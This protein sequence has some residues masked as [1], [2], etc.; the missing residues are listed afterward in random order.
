MDG[1][2]Y[3]RL[4]DSKRTDP[5][6]YITMIHTIAS[7]AFPGPGGCTFPPSPFLIPEEYSPQ[8][9]VQW[10]DFHGTEP[11]TNSTSGTSGTRRTRGNNGMS[12]RDACLDGEVYDEL[13]KDIFNA[14]KDRINMFESLRG[15]DFSDP[16]RIKTF[17]MKLRRSPRK[18]FLG[19]KKRM[20]Q[21]VL[22]EMKLIRFG[23]R[24]PFPDYLLL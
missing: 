13:M 3:Q 11:P 20:I 4:Y 7:G 12:I 23:L 17:L 18:I 15:V 22:L 21:R 19:L 8:Q 10:V 16:P 9:C 1:A 5:D 6:N 24:H 2:F 14:R